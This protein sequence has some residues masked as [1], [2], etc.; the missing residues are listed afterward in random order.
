M[1]SQSLYFHPPDES[2][3]KIEEW[4]ALLAEEIQRNWW[5]ASTNSFITTGYYYT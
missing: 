5:A 1:T 3:V 2:P 4:E